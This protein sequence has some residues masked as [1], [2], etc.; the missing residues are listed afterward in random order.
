MSEMLGAVGA[1]LQRKRVCKAGWYLSVFE[2]G[3]TE[4]VL[5]SGVIGEV[6]FMDG[7]VVGGAGIRSEMT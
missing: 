5:S 6:R 7:S 2:E 4:R 1:F 3:R